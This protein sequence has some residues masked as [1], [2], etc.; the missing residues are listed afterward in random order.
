MTLKDG[1]RVKQGMLIAATTSLHDIICFDAT[2]LYGV[3]YAAHRGDRLSRCLR[4]VR[5]SE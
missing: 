2:P 4:A 1:E 5:V 3:L